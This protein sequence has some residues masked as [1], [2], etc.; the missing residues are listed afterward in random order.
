MDSRFLN[1][2]EPGWAKSL[3]TQ[4]LHG[5]EILTIQPSTSST[6][7]Y[8]YDLPT[9]SLLLFGPASGF[10]VKCIFEEEAADKTWSTIP[11]A[12]SNKVAL[13][14][15]WF[16]HLIKDVGVFQNNTR[17]NCHDVPRSADPFI[18]TYIFAHMHPEIKK[19]LFPEPQNPGN[20][21][22]IKNDDWDLDTDT[23]AWRKYA[24]QV[25]GNGKLMFR[26]IP[27]FTFPFYQDAN[28]CIEKA[29]TVLPMPLI[30][31]MTISLYMKDNLDC[32][33][34]K[35]A[36]NTGKY[37]VRIESIDLIVEEARC[38]PAFERQFLS[39]KKLFYYNGMTRAAVA[40]N[41]ASGDLHHRAKIQNVAMP[42]GMF[43]C[44][45]PKTAVNG[46]YKST[47]PKKE[48]FE[49]HNIKSVLVKYANMPF[50]MKTPKYGE[51][52]HHIM[53]IKSLME[54][55]EQPPFGVMQDPTVIK[56]ESIKETGDET[57]YPH[58]YMTFC[59]SGKESRIVPIGDDGNSVAQ[60]H[61][62]EID[63]SFNTEGATANV[64]YMIYIFYSD[65]NMVFDMQTRQLY[66]YYNRLSKY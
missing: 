21:V 9:N 50:A 43:I 6:E 42:E 20:C 25:Y 52:R 60:T 39:S 56:Y 17:I 33:F 55:N 66:K 30:G 5:V 4:A 32:I 53:E 10:L 26:Y 14:P 35:K 34:M 23:S 62:L 22:P 11:V 18:N 48:V 15:N 29:P 2:Q 41:I 61:D 64:I 7:V 47:T 3:K 13:Q 57:A 44:A 65:V 19:Y 1:S 31:K 24:K 58:V 38:K 8:E 49:K 63:I 46:T 40:E 36:D 51:M 37:R 27:S 16:E 59:P 28:F 54:H 45:L 12:D